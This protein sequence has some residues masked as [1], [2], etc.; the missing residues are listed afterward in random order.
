MGGI[1]PCHFRL[2]FRIHPRGEETRKRRHV[3]LFRRIRRENETDSRR[4]H[5]SKVLG[6]ADA[7][8][9]QVHSRA[10]HGDA[11]LMQACPSGVR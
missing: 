2:R 5:R 9:A 10:G 6:G 8:R 11:F 4:Y 7:S 1:T 3:Y